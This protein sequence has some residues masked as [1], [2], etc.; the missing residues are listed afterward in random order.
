MYTFTRSLMILL[1]SASCFCA[2]SAWEPGWQELDVPLIN[3]KPLAIPVIFPQQ[4]NDQ[5][6]APWPRY[7]YMPQ[8]A[9]LLVNAG[10]PQQTNLAW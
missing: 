10:R 5:T 3:N 9:N 6:Q 4:I 2:G 1:L 8:T 7:T